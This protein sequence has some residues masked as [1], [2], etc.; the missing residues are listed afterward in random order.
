MKRLEV[1]ELQ[2]EILIK[3]IEVLT[4]DI[5]FS[6]IESVKEDLKKEK[7]TN[8][9]RIIRNAYNILNMLAA[10][11]SR[12]LFLNGRISFTNDNGKI[13]QFFIDDKI[14]SIERKLFKNCYISRDSDNSYITISLNNLIGIEDYSK[15]SIDQII[16]PLETLTINTKYN[17]KLIKKLKEMLI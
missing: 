15:I 10:I 14:H 6:L 8:K 9:K 4:D 16:P 1:S 17:Q 2:L 5:K 11:G 13:F 12:D 3:S 7:K